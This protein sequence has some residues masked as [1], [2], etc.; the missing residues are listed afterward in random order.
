MCKLCNAALMHGSGGELLSAIYMSTKHGDT[1]LAAMHSDCLL[2]S[3]KPYW[4][5]I[6]S[7]MTEGQLKDPYGEFFV[8]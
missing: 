7:W 4:F 2:E 8:R 3:I 1:R 5:M 6:R